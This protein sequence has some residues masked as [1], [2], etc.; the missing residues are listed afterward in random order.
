MSRGKIP[1]DMDK[2]SLPLDIVHMRERMHVWVNMIVSGPQCVNSEF[3]NWN[4]LETTT[5]RFLKTVLS[6]P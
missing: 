3:D 4:C 1:L 5:P 2:E 6:T